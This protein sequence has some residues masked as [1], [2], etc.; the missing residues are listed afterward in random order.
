MRW[1]ACTICKFYF[2]LIISKTCEKIK[3]KHLVKFMKKT[4]ITKKW[5]KKITGQKTLIAKDKVA[6]ILSIY[7]YSTKLYS[8]NIN[9]VLHLIIKSDF[10]H[11]WSCCGVLPLF[12]LSKSS[13]IVM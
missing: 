1:G 11:P 9:I 6:K 2:F 12:Y 8:N 3:T 13:R 5:K 7:N 10:I 4:Q